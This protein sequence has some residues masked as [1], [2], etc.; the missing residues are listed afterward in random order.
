[1]TPP[2]HNQNFLFGGSDTNTLFCTTIHIKERRSSVPGV[3]RAGLDGLVSRP[4][5][6]PP[7]EETAVP[8]HIL[9]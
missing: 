1:M 8:T 7:E 4:V 9:T 3:F 2:P 6:N 5:L